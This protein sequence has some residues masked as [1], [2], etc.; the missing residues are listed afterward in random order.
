MIQS[1]KYRLYSILFIS[2]FAA[3]C[4]LIRWFLGYK[5][6]LTLKIDA[7][8]T[9]LVCLS[10]FIFF[11]LNLFLGIY[12]K[13]T[14]AKGFSDISRK[15]SPANYWVAIALWTLFSGGFAVAFVCQILTLFSVKHSS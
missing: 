13:Q 4:Q 11:G 9:G 1:P 10:A 15:S 3:A 5:G 6:M 12:E 14:W 7:S 2:I 8:I